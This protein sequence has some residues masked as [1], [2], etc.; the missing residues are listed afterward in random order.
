M[1][2]NALL[3]LFCFSVQVAKP[4]CRSVSVGEQ[5]LQQNRLQPMSASPSRTHCSFR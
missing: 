5:W 1:V 3:F 4:R 2:G